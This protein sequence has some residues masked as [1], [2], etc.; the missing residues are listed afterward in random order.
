[1]GTGF[2]RRAGLDT[3][4]FFF[5]GDRS[6]TGGGGSVVIVAGAGGEHN[7]YNSLIADERDFPSTIIFLKSSEYGLRIKWNI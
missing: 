1:V 5:G 4:I 2:L 3:L 6:S 7:W